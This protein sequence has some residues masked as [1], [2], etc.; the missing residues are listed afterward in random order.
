MTTLPSCI[1]NIVD[2][3]TPIGSRPNRVD[4]LFVEIEALALNDQLKAQIN[5][6]FNTVSYPMDCFSR[7]K[8]KILKL[9]D[10]EIQEEFA[11]SSH[12][13]IYEG[14][15]GNGQNYI[16]FLALMIVMKQ[17]FGDDHLFELYSKAQ[18][19][20]PNS[21]PFLPNSD[22]FSNQIQQL[23]EKKQS[24][25]QEKL[26]DRPFELREKDGVLWKCLER[27]EFNGGY[28][29][30]FVYFPEKEITAPFPAV[31]PDELFSFNQT[32][33]ETQEKLQE[34][35]Y[36]RESQLGIE[37]LELPDCAVLL[38]KTHTLGLEDKLSVIDAPGIADDLEFAECVA[39][40][41]II[42]SRGAEFVHDHIAHVVVHI[43]NILNEKSEEAKI[44]QKKLAQ[45]IEICKIAD[46]I[47]KC[48]PYQISEYTVLS[49]DSQLSAGSLEES[50]QINEK[51]LNRLRITTGALADSFSSIPLNTT[52]ESFLKLMP[53]LSIEEMLTEIWS[54]PDWNK[55]LNER[56]NNDGLGQWE[57]NKPEQLALFCRRILQIQMEALV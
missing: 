54:D 56:L 52:T 4:D 34:W 24:E 14:Q 11:R 6:S 43:Q 45:I 26:K 1:F 57:Q 2:G 33:S 15:Y 19:E 21:I 10:D 55:Y 41:S 7:A 3:I 20:C 44:I 49:Q 47:L 30:R 22:L 37:Y 23:K 40:G 53:V 51:M 42:L 12:S 8:E 48:S 35:G 27:K 25:I 9:N 46:E 32:N 16:K 31:E 50:I 5:C 17:R 36:Y 29:Y 39:A 13:Q 28:I 38:E 18:K